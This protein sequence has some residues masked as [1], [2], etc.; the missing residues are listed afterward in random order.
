[1]PE[2]R[3]FRLPLFFFPLRNPELE[4][5]FSALPLHLLQHSH[6]NSL[7]P[8]SFIALLFISVILL[9]HQQFNGFESLRGGLI[10]D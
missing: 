10:Q 4:T 3:D 9:H 5:L 6:V 2:A 7:Y 8:P 1:M